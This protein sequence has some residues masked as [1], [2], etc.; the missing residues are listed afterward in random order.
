MQKFPFLILFTFA[1]AAA[2]APAPVSAEF[3]WPVEKEKKYQISSTFGESRIDHFHNGID[4][5]GEGIKVLAPRDSRILYRINAEITP[6]EMPFGGG[7]TLILDHGA[8]AAG[9]TWTGYMHLN[10]VSDAV[11]KN[12]PLARGEKIGSSGNTG[13]SGGAHLHFFVY[14][15]GERAVVNPLLLMSDAYYRDKKPPEIK[16]WGV[17]LTEKFASVNPEKPFRLSSDFPVY[18]LLQDHGVGAERWGV[19]DYRVL[20]DDK[21]VISATFDKILFRND[22]WRLASGQA[23]EEIFYRNQYSLTTGVRKAKRLSIE[24]RDL[25]NNVFRK[26]FDLKIQQN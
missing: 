24:A 6:G 20:L 14:Q 7:N 25:K 17:L 5:P 9:N 12:A 15:T 10:A 11:L 21:L 26:T 22:S 2:D 3:D 4:L 16:E 18:A 23:F 19:Y 1:L 8:S 13:H